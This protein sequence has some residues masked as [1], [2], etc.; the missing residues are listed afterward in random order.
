MAL[1]GPVNEGSL[2]H[3]DSRQ[4]APL[5]IASQEKSA[6]EHLTWQGGGHIQTRWKDAERR[7]AS[8]YSGRELGV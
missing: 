7:Q 6:R 2:E 4:A 8:I 1:W 5:E 3:F